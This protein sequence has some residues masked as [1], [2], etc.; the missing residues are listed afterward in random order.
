LDFH[1]G[2]IMALMAL[3]HAS[4]LV[5]R[6]H[7]Q[8][9]WGAALPVFPDSFWFM[10]R[11]LTHVCAP[12]FAMLM[13]VGIVL[14][15]EAR[16]RKGWDMTH[17]RRYLINRGMLLVVLQLL[18]EDPAWILGIF[19]AHPGAAI[20]WG[21]MAGGGSDVRLHLGV[22]FSL[23]MSMM[24]WALMLELP[25][26]TIALLSTLTL[27]VTEYLV[28]IQPGPGALVAPW[29][30]VLAVAGHTNAWDVAYP[31]L[32][33][34]GVS[35]LGVLIGRG[36][37]HDQQATQRSALWAAV[38]LALLFIVLRAAG[39]LGNLNSVP[40]GLAGFFTVVKYPP[41]IA[42]VA[43]TLSLNLALLAQ[44]SRLP[45]W[46]THAHNPLVTF[47]RCALMF[48][49]VHLWLFA[50]MGLMFRGGAGPAT[51]LLAWITGLVL[52]WLF[53]RWYLRFRSTRRVNS[54]WQFF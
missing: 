49:L 12:G 54:M 14:L 1:R 40:P 19:S 6:R 38:G 29:L 28:S 34:L 52:M 48:Y 31:V 26:W 53:C 21:D 18:V 15:V 36:L 24:V 8:E 25:S 45:G 7:A 37:L 2:L 27:I 4:M 50:A 39:G 30:R 3:D 41:S 33:W 42:F 16:V 10:V 35:G 20:T 32:P 5:A 13:G 11:W 23:G 47:G 22:L 43:V 46:M 9:Y 44:W 51:M 17:V